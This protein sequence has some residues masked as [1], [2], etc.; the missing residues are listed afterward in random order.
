MSSP[1]QIKWKAYREILGMLYSACWQC[2]RPCDA[3]RD[4]ARATAF[5]RVP[6][7]DFAEACAETYR[8]VASMGRR[9]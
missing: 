3:C 6:T 9:P 7:G 2:P 4:W 8:V 1:R 5:G